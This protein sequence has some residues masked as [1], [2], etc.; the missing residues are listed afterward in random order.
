VR[1]KPKDKPV[2]TEHHP[3]KLQTFRAS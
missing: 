1:I 3:E 2:M